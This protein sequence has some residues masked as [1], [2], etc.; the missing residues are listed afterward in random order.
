VFKLP[1]THSTGSLNKRGAASKPTG[2]LSH[3]HLPIPGIPRLYPSQRTANSRRSS[4]PFAEEQPS[5]FEHDFVEVGEVGS[6]E[7]G[8]VIKVRLKDGDDSEVYAVKQSKRFEGVRHRSVIAKFVL[9]VVE[10]TRVLFDSLRLKEEVEVLKHLSQVSALSGE[11]RHPNVLA[12]VDSWEEHEMLYIQTELC[13]SGNLAR[14][15]WEY[16]RVF[17]R[18]DE[19]R[20]WKILVDLGNVSN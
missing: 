6:G 15:L 5:R 13:E 19:G 9:I 18:L 4:E 12:Y 14:F 7:F 3:G 20:V 17:P 11:R 8:K 16:G 1:S 2:I 10:L